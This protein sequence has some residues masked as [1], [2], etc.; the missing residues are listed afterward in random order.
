M[1]RH[2]SRGRRALVL[3]LLATAMVGGAVHHQGASAS[4]ETDL[5]ELPPAEERFDELYDDDGCLRTGL[6]E[7]DCSITADELDA[8]LSGDEVTD[9]RHLEGFTGSAW[10]EDLAAGAPV[11][12]EDS[13]ATVI[14]GTVELS[15][16]VRNE[17]ADTLDAIAVTAE[18]LDADGQAIGTLTA[19]ALVQTVRSGEPVPFVVSGPAPAVPVADVAWSA[20]AA[21]AAPVERALAW[22]PFWT[23]PAGERDP[24]D[25]HL[26]VERGDGP[27]P[28]V[29]F[30]SVRNLTGHALSSATVTTAWLDDDGRIVAIAEVDAVDQAGDVVIGFDPDASADALLV[31]DDVPAGARALTWVSGSR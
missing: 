15:G 11:V 16:L 29:T 5:P 9:V 17:S 19:E 30:G 3:G 1:E 18:L 25:T 13:V 28:Q 31:V 27:H 4:T 6:G 23:Q 22:Q 8:V 24:L 2:H 12:L 21:P 7:Q 26:Y 20:A 10:T 14:D